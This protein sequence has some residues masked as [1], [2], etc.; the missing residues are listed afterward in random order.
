MSNYG[1]VLFLFYE[2]LGISLFVLVLN[3]LFIYRIWKCIVMC[4]G[5][6]E[7]I[8]FYSGCVGGVVL[9]VEEGVILFEF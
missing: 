5:I 8:I 9:L 3:Y 7:N 4:V 1:Y 6:N 2:Y